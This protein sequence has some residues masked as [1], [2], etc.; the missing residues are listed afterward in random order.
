MDAAIVHE[1][2]EATLKPLSHLTGQAA[3]DWLHGEAIRRAPH[4]KMPITAAA[5]RIL[6]QYRQASGLAP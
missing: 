4:T 3:I 2:I 6:V 5:R 1:Y